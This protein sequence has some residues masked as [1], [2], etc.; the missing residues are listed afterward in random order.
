MPLVPVTMLPGISKVNSDYAAGMPMG[1]A[2]GRIARGRFVDGNHVRFVAGFPEKIG[3]WTAAT[4]ALVTGVPRAIRS[5]RS[6]ASLPLVGIGTSQK[7]Y[8]FNGQNLTDITPLRPIVTGNLANGALST[9]LGSN[10]VAV[11]DPANQ[12]ANGDWVQVIANT[13]VGGLTIDGWYQVSSAAPGAGY[14]ITLPLAATSSD[15]GGGVITFA[16]PRVTLTNPFTTTLGSAVV[17]VIHTAHGANNGDRVAF[18][19][20]SP[21]GGLSLD[22][23]Y[24][25]TYV[26]ANTYTITAPAVAASSATGGG[27]VSVTYDISMQQQVF[28]TGIGYGQVPYG[29]GVFGLDP[30]VVQLFANGWTLAPYGGFLLA[31]PIGGTVYVYDPQSSG[32]AYP[33]INAPTDIIAMFVTP[34]RFVVALGTANSTLQMAWAD[35]ND[36]TDWTSTPTNTAN[37]GRTLQGGSLLIGG[38]PVTN[39]VSLVFTDRAVFTMSYTGDNN[40]YSTLMSGDGA[41]LLGPYAVAVQGAVAYWMSDRD[42]WT[43]NGSAQRLPS[44]DIRDYVFTNINKLY[45]SKSFAGMNR[46]KNEVWFFY[47]SAAST[48]IDSYVIYHI[49]QGCWSIGTMNRTAW[50][51]ADYFPLPMTGDASGMIYYQEVGSDAN[52][53]VLDSYIEFAPA[54]VSNGSSNVDVFGFLPD[55]E[56][57]SQPI[58]LTINTRYYPQD[59]NQES[60]PFT[61]TAN[62][63]TPRIDLRADGK[64]VGF[65]LE[66]AAIGGDWRIGVPRVDIQPSGARR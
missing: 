45:F 25:L 7:L 55:F 3:G 20:S 1:Y 5:W 60:G 44:D 29:T 43:W 34:E 11:S 12:L 37:S 54:D 64:M 56:R 62:D 52:G 28:S 49:D 2:N 38:V 18:T 33:L 22:G 51:D 15:T 9:T 50:T 17:T 39:G 65:T 42:F 4:Q 16:Y 30:S 58:N 40:V 23:E 61:I 46:A 53:Q 63:T 36:F 32:R 24:T 41:G 21:V 59:A 27:S 48:E 26:D 13:S 31:A 19:G 66:S 10:L 35:Q 57:L 47:C 14:N 8:V 6:T